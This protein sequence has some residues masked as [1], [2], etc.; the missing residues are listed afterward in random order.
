M[1]F[2]LSVILLTLPLHF[3]ERYIYFCKISFLRSVCT[4][5]MTDL[6][7]TR[8]QIYGDWRLQLRNVQCVTQY[9]QSPSLRAIRTNVRALCLKSPSDSEQSTQ[10]GRKYV[11]PEKH[12]T[13]PDLKGFQCPRR[14]FK[15]YYS[16]LHASILP[17]KSQKPDLSI[18]H[19]KILETWQIPIPMVSY[20]STQVQQLAPHTLP[21]FFHL[22]SG[23]WKSN[24][25]QPAFHTLWYYKISVSF[26]FQELQAHN[27]HIF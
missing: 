7:S 19:S 23:T 1:F 26:T 25:L 6:Y 14:Q 21:S 10:I 27:T 3:F 9:F 13:K 18:L 20:T 22:L 15:E 2:Y 4:E 12:K 24:P 8:K 16:P 5:L 17:L 11:F